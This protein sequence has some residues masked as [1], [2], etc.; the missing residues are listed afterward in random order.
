MKRRRFLLAGL[1]LLLVSVLVAGCGGSSKSSEEGDTDASGGAKKKVTLQ[2]KWVT[3]AQFAGYYAAKA[4][5]YY[6]E[7]GLDVNIKIGGPGLR[8]GQVVPGQQAGFGI[9][10][11]P[12]P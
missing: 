8:P 7:E 9:D 3:Q 10:W 11:L 2:L 6:D 5:G 4:K 1:V 12:A